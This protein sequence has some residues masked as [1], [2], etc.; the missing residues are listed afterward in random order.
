MSGK[1]T[2]PSVPADAAGVA[3]AVAVLREGGLVAIPTETVYGLAARADKEAAVARIFAAK[4]RPSFNPLIVHVAGVDEAA[5]LAEMTPDVRR[6]A[7][8]SWPGPVTLVMPR[9]A[10]A[11]LAPSVTAG[12]HT[13][14][15]RVPRHR[16]ALAVIEALGVPLAAPSANRSG[17]V[18]PTTPAHVLETLDGRIDL[19]LDA[20]PTERG[21]EST[22]LKLRADG[23]W[24][25]L[26]PG[27]IDTALWH[28]SHFAGE[29]RGSDAAIEAP[30]QLASHY[31]PGKPVRLGALLAEPDEFLIGFGVVDGEVTLSASADFDEAAQRF[32]AC[33][34]DAARS[35]KPRIAVAPI[36]ETGVGVAINDR[37]RRAAAPSD[38]EGQEPRAIELNHHVRSS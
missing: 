35:D 18:S 11:P 7:Q 15:I 27:P 19:V 10:D 33:L 37:L 20:G 2:T 28:D 5:A 36:P 6:F 23:R 1:T 17:F 21:L 8:A 3:R 13:V 24:E 25:E 30:G 9:R 31:S 34:H 32:Y 4:G 12:L 22:I 26:R 14:A 16:V 29:L 38:E